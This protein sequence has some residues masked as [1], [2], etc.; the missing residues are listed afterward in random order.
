MGLIHTSVVA[1]INF[2]DAVTQKPVNTRVAG[3][4][5]KQDN[6]VVWKDNSCVVILNNGKQND[7]DIWVEGSIYR[8][9]S[10]HIPFDSKTVPHIYN[11]WMT[12]SEKYPFSSNMTIIKG[13]SEQKEVLL[14]RISA[15]GAIRL[16]EDANK[17]D[18][19]RLWGIYGNIEDRQ[20]IIRDGKK[21]EIISLKG[22]DKENNVYYT[23]D[24]LKGSYRKEDSVIYPV[25]RVRTDCDGNYIMAYMNMSQGDKVEVL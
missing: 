14:A 25:T 20:L 24:K 8:S 1:V 12:P 15:L 2:I 23:V 17:V 21:S 19:I 16:L 6:K 4:V 13:R 11:E 22:A 18:Y 9:F 7:I 5:L 10:L 3:L